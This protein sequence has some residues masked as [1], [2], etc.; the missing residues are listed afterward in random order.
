MRVSGL[1]AAPQHNGRLG[2][3][4][5][6]LENGRVA[7][8]LDGDTT[9]KSFRRENIEFV[10]T[11]LSS[12]ATAA[13]A[14][15]QALRMQDGEVATIDMKELCRVVVI[16]QLPRKWNSDMLD[17]RSGGAHRT[18]LLTKIGSMLYIDSK[19][20]LGF[21]VTNEPEVTQRKIQQYGDEC[22]ML[23]K[24]KPALKRL[25]VCCM[26]GGCV[27]TIGDGKP[28][29]R[30]GGCL[31]P[32]FCSEQCAAM[33]DK[34]ARICSPDP[35][36]GAD[37]SGTLATICKVNAASFGAL[38][39][40]F[41]ESYQ[42]F[43]FCFR[44]CPS[45]CLQTATPH[46]VRAMFANHFLTCS[47]C[48]KK[49]DT[50]TFYCGVCKDKHYCSSS[51]KES[52]KAHHAQHCTPLHCRIEVSASVV[53][54]SVQYAMPYDHG[55]KLMKLGMQATGVYIEARKAKLNSDEVTSLR[56]GRG[57]C[58]LRLEEAKGWES[59]GDYIG[60]LKAYWAAAMYY[61]ELDDCFEGCKVVKQAMKTAAETPPI[62]RRKHL[63]D[64][65]LLEEMLGALH[66]LAQSALNDALVQN[67]KDEII[68]VHLAS[69][70]RTPEGDA[71]FKA[72]ESR[73]SSARKS[74]P[75]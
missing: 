8:L 47:L 64:F 41:K 6:E 18:A 50:H 13:A 5:A 45:H 55:A 21:V 54:N 60:A 68:R 73:P 37:A 52:H 7:V 35:A 2:T 34:H 3:H 67:F 12:S 56:L 20:T 49:S 46:Q 16:V 17:M 74:S 31:M 40:I 19:T 26:R 28:M 69:E 58:D 33:D 70:S 11:F 65:V 72:F 66:G 48:G 43:E 75:E 29:V 4:T 14:A 63:A 39:E 44:E 10:K 32:R 42:D 27:E 53:F 36:A 23:I 59:L 62:F 61:M 71:A 22:C 24:Y 1:T 51:C 30:C 15:G 25:N 57:A 9:T 38:S